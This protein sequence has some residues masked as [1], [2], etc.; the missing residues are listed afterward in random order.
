MDKEL[1]LLSIGRRLVYKNSA[2]NSTTVDKESFDYSMS[3]KA[4]SS[5][6]MKVQTGPPDFVALYY[7]MKIA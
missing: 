1:Q 7:I 2:S 5:S 4:L 3:T 6:T